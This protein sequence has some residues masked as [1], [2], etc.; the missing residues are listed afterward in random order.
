MSVNWIFYLERDTKAAALCITQL[1]FCDWNTV[2][3]YSALLYTGFLLH[4]AILWYGDY[5]FIVF[6][7]I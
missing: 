7:L 3:D 4:V 2:Q 5:F 6:S 1:P